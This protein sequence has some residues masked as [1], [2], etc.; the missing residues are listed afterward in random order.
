MRWAFGLFITAYSY[1]TLYLNWN[2][3]LMLCLYAMNKVKFTVDLVN[4]AVRMTV[5]KQT[6]SIQAASR[7]F[8]ILL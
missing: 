6:Y 5:G 8:S 7:D 4:K 1:L 3:V 2:L